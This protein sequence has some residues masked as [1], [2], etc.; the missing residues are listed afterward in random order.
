MVSRKILNFDLRQIA[1]SGQCFR[2]ALL[3]SE[4]S[5]CT[6][7]SGALFLVLS[8]D[9]AQVSFSCP[10]GD[11]PYWER[12]FDLGADYGA[13]ISSI[14]DTDSYLKRAAAFGSG[15]R[16]LRQDPWE[17]I[18]TFI[19]SQQ[20]TIPAIRSL[21]EALCT[22]YGT[23]MEIQT[24]IPLPAGHPN[25]YYTFPTPEQLSRASLEDLLAL[26]LGYRAKYIKKVCEDAC[27]GALDL[28]RLE[29]MD[30]PSAMEYLQ[31]FYGIGE[32]VANCVCLFGL[33]HIDAF[34]VDT[35][36]R[37]VLLKEYASKSRLPAATPKSRL[38]DALVEEHFSRYRGFAGVMQQYIFFYE[39]A[40]AKGTHRLSV[41][42]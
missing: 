13:Y 20:K 22:N 4:G 42:K 29:A 2:M 37:K 35:W 34:P 21:V 39:R 10:E 36:I 17:M 40:A 12:Y 19:I 32:K 24:E 31:G 9:G 7:I 23:R 27:S 6:V 28:P 5:L 41:V 8:Q 14:S 3:E 11:F 18:I 1:D 16:I 25:F 30:Y 15:I 26:K 33:H 38:C